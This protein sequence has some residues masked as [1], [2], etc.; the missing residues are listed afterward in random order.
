M[1]TLFFDGLTAAVKTLD[2]LLTAV[3]GRRPGGPPPVDDA[4]PAGACRGAMPP[5]ARLG[6][7]R[8]DPQTRWRPSLGDADP[9]LGAGGHPIRSTSEL[10]FNA[11]TELD[12]AY[13]G[14]QHAVIVHFKYELADRAAQLQAEGD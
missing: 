14:P 9:R 1:I 3:D 2:R 6:V 12:F 10:L 13:P 5:A 4:Q 11:V 7:P 8:V